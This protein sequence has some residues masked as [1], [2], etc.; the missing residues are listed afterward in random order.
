MNEDLA[1]ATHIIESSLSS[2]G[3]ISKLK[4]AAL[5]ALCVMKFKNTNSRELEGLKKSE[6]TEKLIDWVSA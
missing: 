6:L 3:Q 5:V 1:E 4:K 2:H